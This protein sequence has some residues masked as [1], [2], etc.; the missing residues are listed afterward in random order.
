MTGRRPAPPP[1]YGVPSGMFL[2]HCRRLVKDTQDKAAE[3]AGVARPTWS[4]VES[5]EYPC[6]RDWWVAVGH[7]YALGFPESREK[8]PLWF[9]ALANDENDPRDFT[10]LTDDRNAAGLFVD[11]NLACRTAAALQ[12]IGVETAFA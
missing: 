1:L 12:H 4:R 9:L 10:I 3:L 7:R 2:A 11:G 6:H 5:G 8:Q